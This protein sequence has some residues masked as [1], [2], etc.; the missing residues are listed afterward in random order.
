MLNSISYSLPKKLENAVQT[1]FD[2]WQKE[3]KISRIW[4]QDASVWTNTDEAK[5]LGW[6]DIV[7]TELSDLQKYRDFAETAKDFSDI[8][9]LGMGGSSL[10]PEVFSITFGKQ[11]FYNLDSTVPAQ[12]KTLESKI[13]LANTLF[14]VASKSGSTLEPNTFKQYF[15]ERVSGLVGRENAGRQFAAITD[16]N[17]KMQKVAEQ[18]NFRRIFF[19]NAEIGGRFSVLS[20]F[21]MIPASAMGID[22]EDFLNRTSEM[23][24]A[25]KNDNPI[26][27]AGAVLGTI[28][29]V[30]QTSGRDKLTIFT[31]PEIHDV[32]AWLEQLIAESTG[33][34]DIAIV[35]VDREMIQPPENYGNDRIFAY[36][37]LEGES[38]E[39]NEAK[40]AALEK[41]GQPVVRI[42]LSDKMNL[43]Q[44]FFRWEFATAIAGAIM[45]INP[46]NQP[47]VEAAKIEAKKLTEEYEKTGELPDEKPFFEE[48]GVKLFTDKK[49]AN[50]LTKLVGAESLANYFKAHFSRIKKDDYFALLAYVEMNGDTEN[51]LQ[52][53]RHSVL[54]DKKVATCLGFGP[55]FLHS[56]GQAYKGGANNGVVLQI[57]SD[58]V[59]DLPVP[60]QKYTFGV[61]KAAQ[62]RGDF[63]V[64]LDRERRALR[65][66]LV[67]DAKSGLE[68][69]LSLISNLQ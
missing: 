6:L 20:V 64:L 2:E 18:D 37:K 48:S 51:L 1:K 47:D 66:H 11:N 56:T 30:C 55:R 52:K 4:K 33:K 32:G 5:W 61:V 8:V 9:L 12:I 65:V 50:E 28:L 69:I 3:N 38:N 60:D 10:G 27:N 59:E 43:G 45:N 35:P 34:D 17:S 57:T 21:G 15:Y 31:S 39:A 41:S 14:I 42:T 36:L 63:Q 16:P 40:I 46:F 7:K 68:K 53:I 13:N 62:A 19:G 24:S 26:E 23:V 25:C 67:A 22:V 29:G 58:D 44:E 49:N 54:E